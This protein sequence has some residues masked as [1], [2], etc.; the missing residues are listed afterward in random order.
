LH[1]RAR[2]AKIHFMGESATSAV[3]VRPEATQ[4]TPHTPVPSL[5]EARKARTQRDLIAHSRRLTLERG[6]GGFTLDELCQ[7]AGISRRTFFNYFA[8]KD[9][10][11]LGISLG[12]TFAGHSQEFLESRGTVSLVDAVRILISGSFQTM[13]NDEFTPDLMSKVLFS[14]PALMSRMHEHAY[15]EVLELENLICQREGLPAGSSYAHTIA[16]VCHQT[17]LH[18][19][20]EHHLN[21]HPRP[22][23]HHQRTALHDASCTLQVAVYEENLKRNFAHLTAFFSGKDSAQ[24]PL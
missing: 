17:S 19:F 13:V 4:T 7:E 12:S 15:G 3:E 22:E 10:A 1:L 14:H 16:M 6:L 5:R 2:S 24:H 9:D 11:V 18:T 21:P 20:M 8:S 23:Q